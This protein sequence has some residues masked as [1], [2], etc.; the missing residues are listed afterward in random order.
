MIIMPAWDN[1]SGN[2]VRSMTEVGKNLFRGITILEGILCALIAPA[3]TSG[4]IS[5]EREQQTLDLLL[6][7]RLSNL[8]ILFG[9]LLSAL[10]FIAMVLICAMPVVAISFLLGGVAP[11][12]CW[13]AAIIFLTACLFS[14]IGLYC[15]TRYAKTST[16]VAIAY[17]ICLAS[18][19]ILPLLLGASMTF[20]DATDDKTFYIFLTGAS[21]LFAVYPMLILCA[22]FIAILRR[23]LHWL[24]GLSCWAVSA[25]TCCWLLATFQTP[26]VQAAKNHASIF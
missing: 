9:K 16:A 1:I 13:S 23:P 20:L 5:I 24:V 14:M 2:D 8:N 4:A 10:S 18:L 17:C 15:S 22:L 19:A 3:L 25:A 12:L 6:L 7:T 21:A 26:I 11:Q